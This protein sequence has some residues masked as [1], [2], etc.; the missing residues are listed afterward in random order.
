[1]CQDDAS[2]SISSQ[3]NAEKERE[4]N[5]GIRVCSDSLASGIDPQPTV[6]SPN[7]AWNPIQHYVANPNPKNS[8]SLTPNSLAFRSHPS[9][10]RLERR[11]PP[12]PVA[13][14]A[15]RGKSETLSRA[16]CRRESTMHGKTLVYHHFFVRA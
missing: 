2:F 7:R 13:V 6:V 8:T 9:L 16:L 1:V 5:K 14:A 3:W 15:S 12:H 11:F 4:E 10:M